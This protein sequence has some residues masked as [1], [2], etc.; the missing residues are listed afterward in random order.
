ME[1]VGLLNE[2][3]PL[4]KEIKTTQV[5]SAWNQ[6]KKR[7][8]GDSDDNNG[9][10]ECSEIIDI[11]SLIPP[12]ILKKR[13]NGYDSDTSLEEIEAEFVNDIQNINTE[14]DGLNVQ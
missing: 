14:D 6:K 4:M 10:G 8:K 3:I 1:T 5:K 12:Q 11:L 7:S 9:S 2:E 13:A